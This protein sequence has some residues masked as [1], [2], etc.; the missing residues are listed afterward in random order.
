MVS[1]GFLNSRVKHRGGDCRRARAVN[2]SRLTAEQAAIRRECKFCMCEKESR[3]CFICTDETN[4]TFGKGECH[5]VCASCMETHISILNQ[6]WKWSR[7]V[8]CPCQSGAQITVPA[9]MIPEVQKIQ[10]ER[11]RKKCI[12]DEAL[13]EVCNVYCPGCDKAFVDFDGCCALHCEC[14]QYFCAFCFEAQDTNKACHDHVSQC[15]LSPNPGSYYC[16]M[17]TW[18][19]QQERAKRKKLI[20]FLKST[21]IS[22]RLQKLALVKACSDNG[23]SVFP[24]HMKTAGIIVYAAMYTLTPRLMLGFIS[25]LLLFMLS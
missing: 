24:K 1:Y 22:S 9:E 25:M 14:G 4:E 12:V 17:N 6:N 20:Q 11:T 3:T 21:D 10:M 8:T 18:I 7:I 19:E 23:V 5:E 15:S 2:M 16:P 13:N